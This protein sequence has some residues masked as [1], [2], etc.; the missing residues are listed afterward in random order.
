MDNQ[1]HKNQQPW[2]NRPL[3]GDRSMLEKIESVIHKEHE[4]IPEEVIEHHQR[5]MGELKILAPIARALDSDTFINPEFLTF[6]K[7]TKLFA[8][9]IAEY[10]GLRNYVALFRVAIEAKNSFLKIEQIELSHRSTKQQELYNFVI[11]ELAQKPNSEKFIVSLKEKLEKILPEIKTEE[12]I[13]AINSYVQTLELVAR[14]DELGLR[15]LY[16]FKKYQLED[17]SLLRVMSEMVD[18]LL[19]K[20]LQNFAEITSFIEANREKFLQLG[21]IIEIP[22]EKNTDENYARMFQYIVLKRKYNDDYTQFQR[23]IE[24]MTE[25]TKFYKIVKEIREHYPPAEFEQPTEFTKKIPGEELY[26][27]HRNQL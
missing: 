4:H 10:K 16:L 12:G 23:V 2:W 27:K 19:G 1:S 21:K 6:V 9:E 24:I 14:Q 8:L 11:K 5:V 18:Y 15:L 17:L 20:N 3:W 13:F 22:A 26:F 7:V 25:W